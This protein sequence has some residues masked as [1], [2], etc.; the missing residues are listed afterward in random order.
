MRRRFYGAQGAA[1]FAEQ[2][3]VSLSQYESFERG[4]VPTPELLVR[5]CECTGEDLQW[6]LTGVAARSTLV[7][8]ETR[9]RHRDLLTRL[10]MLLDR[11]PRAAASVEAFVDLL[12][13]T[14]EFPAPPAAALP[15]P[16]PK[17]WL[18]L[19]EADEL[20]ETVDALR[21]LVSTAPPPDS[22]PPPRG[23]RRAP[24]ELSAPAAETLPSSVAALEY[25]VEGG[26]AQ[27]LWIG[28]ADS[29][30]SLLGAFA[31]RIPDLQM[32]PIFDPGDAA[33]VSFSEAPLVGAPAIC[34]L[35]A[36]GAVRCRIWL[37]ST[38]EAAR[39]GR[40]AD[41]AIESV[42]ERDLLWAFRVLWRARLAA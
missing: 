38:A 42:G 6:L 33:I 5:I 41:G 32:Q 18:P 34:R 39:L 13:A 10:A 24:A 1:R 36:E 16:S 40:A 2:L 28:A 31:V 30:D 4:T 37:G 7:I 11:H 25:V 20:P 12:A 9:T 8:A 14:W 27:R 3:G 26:G 15:A 23:R 22:D 17:R 29:G 35:R 19:F 21:E